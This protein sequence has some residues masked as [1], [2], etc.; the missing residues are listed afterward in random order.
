MNLGSDLTNAACFA[1]IDPQYAKH[2]TP[3][4][5]ADGRVMT[6]YRPRC[7][8]YPTLAAAELG[9]NG[10]RQQMTDGALQLMSQ[11]RELNNRKVTSQTC[12]DTMLPDLYKRVCT[13]KGCRTVPGNYQGL[14]VGRVYIPELYRTASAPQAL[15]DATIPRLP[16]TFPRRPP[17]VGSQCASDDPERAFAWKGDAAKYGSAAASHPYSAPRS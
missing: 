4:R 10:V 2:G 17:P 14:G 8:Q 3:A 1:T 11:A 15:S 13:W 5:M 16:G 7:Y 9:D 6:D 12:V